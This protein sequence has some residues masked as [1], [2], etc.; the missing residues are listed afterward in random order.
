MKIKFYKYEAAGN[1][2]LILKDEVLKHPLFKNPPNLRKFIKNL[3]DRHFGVGADEIAFLSFPKTENIDAKVTFFNSDGSGAQICG[4]GLR[5][6]AK[7]LYERNKKIHKKFLTILTDAGPK[8]CKVYPSKNGRVHRV[9]VDM[10]L[11]IKIDGTIEMPPVSKF[12]IPF[13]KLEGFALSFGNPHAVIF[14]DIHENLKEK[15]WNE[16]QKYQLFP[17]GVNVG[18]AVFESPRSIKLEV[19]ERGCGPTLACGSGACA[20]VTSAVSIGHCPF[21]VPVKVKMPGGTLRIKVRKKD[22][23]VFI[24]GPV[25]E[26]FEGAI[27]DVSYFFSSIAR[28]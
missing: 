9:I 16:L 18:Y 15:I 1:D 14:E 8:K 7:H 12:K 5:C 2:V 6:I 11:P 27:E 26:I 21:D 10:G 13:S 4:N 25:R 20:A 19:W 17:E 24:E 3:A 28:I 22:F 23:N